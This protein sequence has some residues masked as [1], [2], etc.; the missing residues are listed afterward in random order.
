MQFL[1]VFDDVCDKAIRYVM[2]HSG[3]SFT[4]LIALT[5]ALFFNNILHFPQ[6]DRNE[7]EF[8]SLL[9]SFF[10]EKNVFNFSNSDYIGIFGYWL[11]IPLAILMGEG[12]EL[13]ITAY[14]IISLI[15]CTFLIIST[16]LLGR[17]L[18]GREAGLNIS[19]THYYAPDFAI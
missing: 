6:I 3:L 16:F 10:A 4:V 19:I 18:F 7:A 11:H 15:G 1:R 17:R 8:A 2:A 9:Q 14:R 5:L 12:S 13:N